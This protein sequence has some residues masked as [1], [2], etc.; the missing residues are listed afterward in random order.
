VLAGLLAVQYTYNHLQENA[1]AATL[2]L[3]S[4]GGAPRFVSRDIATVALR[5]L[6][7]GK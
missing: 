1:F 6:E 3:N 7:G 4:L 5:H 2:I